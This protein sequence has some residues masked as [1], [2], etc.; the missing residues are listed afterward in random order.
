[1]SSDSIPTQAVV[2]RLFSP[3]PIR[4]QVSPQANVDGVAGSASHPA[5]LGDG[6]QPGR[7]EGIRD[8]RNYQSNVLVT[9]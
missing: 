9:S 7:L 3:F 2:Y 1:M 4:I 6:L 8:D 5:P